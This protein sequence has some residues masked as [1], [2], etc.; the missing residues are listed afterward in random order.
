MAESSK[1]KKKKGN[2]GGA[3]K[4]KAND[5]IF[6]QGNDLLLSHAEKARAELGAIDS[7]SA[8]SSMLSRAERVYDVESEK[9]DDQDEAAEAALRSQ[10]VLA[11]DKVALLMRQM[12]QDPKEM[13]AMASIGDR[14][15]C[16]LQLIESL[17]LKLTDIEM[18][19]LAGYDHDD[20]TFRMIISAEAYQEVKQLT[21]QACKFGAFA[22]VLW[23]LA[24]EQMQMVSMPSRRKKDEEEEGGGFNTESTIQWMTATAA[25]I[26][27]ARSSDRL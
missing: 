7:I 1:K 20:I 4:R 25:F 21:A 3:G 24:Y 11:R 2:Q 13:Q 23:E 26:L 16:A 14:K 27:M 6:D 19:S 8:G 12:M 15:A 22:T 18:D 17:A 5:N 10:A 9:R